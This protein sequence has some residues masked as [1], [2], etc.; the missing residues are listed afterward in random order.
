MYMNDYSQPFFFIWFVIFSQSYLFERN[1]MHFYVQKNGL[2]SI[3]TV[4]NQRIKGL[5]QFHPVNI[6]AYLLNYEIIKF[7]I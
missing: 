3:K 6:N 7:S 4:I 1:I 5:I 2:D